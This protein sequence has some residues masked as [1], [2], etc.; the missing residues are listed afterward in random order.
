MR[1]LFTLI[2]ISICLTSTAQE[3]NDLIELLRTDL[4]NQRDTIIHS[5]LALSEKERAAFQPLFDAFTTE[6]RALW[7]DR[8]RLLDDYTKVSEEVTDAQAAD[9][10]D[11][12]FAIEKRDVDLRMKYYKQVRKV[13]PAV[14]A[15]RWVQVERRWGQLLELQAANEIIQLPGAR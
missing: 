12:L 10:I 3:P 14:K 5:A 6:L 15:A 8:L 11:R 13:L 4:R 1:Q 7:D 9:L 2:T